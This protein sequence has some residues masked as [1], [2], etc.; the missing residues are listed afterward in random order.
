MKFTGNLTESP[1]GLPAAG[2]PPSFQPGTVLL[3]EQPGPT[4][5]TGWPHVRAWASGPGR[6]ESRSC[7]C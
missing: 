3:F 6:F 5:D 1:R 7:S 4:A 2:T